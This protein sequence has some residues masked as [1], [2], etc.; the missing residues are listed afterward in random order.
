MGQGRYKVYLA[1]CLIIA[2]G[3]LGAVAATGAT[4]RLGLDLEG[5]IG[6]ILT[7]R[8][9]G[10]S[11]EAI[12]GQAV[13][14][15]RQRIDALGV[16]EPEVSIAGSNNILVQLPGVEDEEQ[17]LDL[18]G[19]T[20]QLTFR[21]VLR[22]L[23][24]RAPGAG[25]DEPRV[26]E[27]TGPEVADER[28]VYPLQD[29]PD[30]LLRLA[31]AALTGEVVTGAEAVI[32]PAGGGWEVSLDMNS[33][34][35][36]RWA[37]LTA[38]QACQRDRQ[39][40][41]RIAIVL[42]GE[43]V[44]APGMDP[45]V[46]CDVGLRGTSSIQTGGEGE[47]KN[48]ALVLRY[49]SLPL[50]L[51]QSEV[52]NVS[53]TLGRDSL[54]AGIR[55]GAIGLGLLLIYVLLYYRVMGLVIWLGLVVFTAMIY[56]LMAFLGET[57]G[58]ALTLAG[59]AGIIVS[60]GITTDSFIVSLERL[61]DEFREGKTLRA[62]V[63]RGTARAVNTMLVADVVTG[64][65][66]VILFVLAVGPVR[67]FALTLGLATLIDVFLIFFFIRPALVLLANTRAFTEGRL[68]GMKEAL[69][70]GRS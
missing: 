33:E 51:E 3:G 14:I 15:I 21:E 32:D 48:L 42:D 12:L 16:A 55:A 27:E 36:D 56:S 70:G 62:A 9:E 5:G 6:V 19:T 54:E 25:D 30:L 17:A 43:V 46:E 67:G 38:E 47:A 69:G 65:A 68:L 40:D 18:I 64:A 1:A 20:A 4:P 52:R 2:F 28:V 45:S 57:A 39:E 37:E 59:V 13:A 50:T 35:A 7:A 22:D 26:T 49:G 11:D 24:A 23:P 44:S 61:K 53:A 29:E 31:P 8:G 34:G 58:L 63:Q 66:A 10:S 41:D 60:I